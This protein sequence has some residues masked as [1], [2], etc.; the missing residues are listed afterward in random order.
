LFYFLTL[1]TL[2]GALAAGTWLPGQYSRPI[3]RCGFGVVIL[4]QA[5]AVAL[6][7]S[8]AVPQASWSR[9]VVEESILADLTVAQEASTST[10]TATDA[11][12]NS[13]ST[14]PAPELSNSDAGNVLELSPYVLDLV[15]QYQQATADAHPSSSESAPARQPGKASSTR[16]SKKSLSRASTRTA[17]IVQEP[18]ASSIPA[19]VQAVTEKLQAM[20]GQLLQDNY[21]QVG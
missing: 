17:A 12:N 9:K 4:L 13:T 8:M 20:F 7:A 14:C 3:V 10:S 1:D 15:D 21:L 11:A 6:T 5:V 2:P 19:E 16:S 18:A